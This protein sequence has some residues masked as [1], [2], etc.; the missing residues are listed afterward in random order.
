MKSAGEII[1]NRGRIWQINKDI[2]FEDFVI[3]LMPVVIDC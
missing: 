1:C 2:S 3:R